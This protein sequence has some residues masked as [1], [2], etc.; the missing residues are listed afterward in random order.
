[1]SLVRKHCML[2]STL[3]LWSLFDEMERFEKTGVVSETA[4]LRSI[5]KMY[6]EDNALSMMV[7]GHEVWR[8]LACR[9][10][11]YE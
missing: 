5:A 7:V 10:D 2:L 8:E 11:D 4:V 3:E 9:G 1:M 6:M